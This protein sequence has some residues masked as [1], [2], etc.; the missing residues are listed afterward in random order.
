MTTTTVTAG[1]L[2]KVRALLDL[3]EH[4]GTPAAE[5]DLARQRAESIMAKY[6]IEVDD[7]LGQKVLAEGVQAP[8][9]VPFDVKVTGNGPF[10]N[11]YAYLWG[12]VVVHVG[13]RSMGEWSYP[14]G[15]ATW[16]ARGVGFEADVQYAEMLFT[17]ARMAFSEYLEPKLD[18][19]ASDQV[20]AYR[21]RRAGMERKRIA[22]I[23]WGNTDKVFMG[24]V[25]R[26]YKAECVQRGE[27]AVLSGRGVTGA[28][29]RQAYAESFVREFENR[30]RRSRS[31]GS[32]LALGNREQ[33]L[34]EAFYARFPDMRPKAAVEGDTWVDPRS[35]CPKC[36]ASKRGECKEH[37][38]PMGRS[39]RGR[40]PYSEAAQRGRASGA[41]A[42]RSVDLGRTGGGRSN[43]IGG[44]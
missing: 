29:Y 43:S 20:N 13:L 30:L 7:L 32:G 23:L 39:S 19:E 42:A 11:Y 14:G 31:G 22:D 36:K 41:D 12:S 2:A 21:L 28:A 8:T 5:A 25:G 37:Y 35:T 27:E 33:V 6:R 38:V 4:E 24:R 1:M 9:P 26:L 10:R 3:A 40:D 15:E 34:N 16:M 17:A 44:A 18:P